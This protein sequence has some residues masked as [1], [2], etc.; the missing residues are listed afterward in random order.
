ELPESVEYD[1]CGT[2]WVAT[3]DDEMQEVK[4]KQQYYSNRG[5]PVEI[6]DEQSLEE[7]EPNLRKRLV[8]GLR[9]KEDVVIYPPAAARFLIER[10]ESRGAD[11]YVGSPVISVLDGSLKLGNDSKFSAGLIVNA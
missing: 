7:A 6:L 2:I 4:R 8:G 10:A 9:I 1:P 5:V 3:D 11:V